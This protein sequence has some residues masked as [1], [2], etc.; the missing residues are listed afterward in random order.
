M[1]FLFKNFFSSKGLI[2]AFFFLFLCFFSLSWSGLNFQ[3]LAREEKKA[4][5]HSLPLA[6]RVEKT[7]SKYRQAVPEKKTLRGKALFEEALKALKE[8]HAEQAEIW[9]SEFL[10][11]KPGSEAA[12]YNLA[13]SLYRQDGKEG[14]AQAYWRQILF[15][16]PYH[17]QSRAG[18]KTL[19][20]RAY[21]WLWLTEDMV[22]ALM[23]LSWAALILALFKKRLYLAR[24]WVFTGLVVHGLGAG[25]FYF[26][27][28]NYST[29][30]RDCSVLS[31]PD[32]AASVLFKQKAGVFLKVKKEL[33]K[34]GDSLQWSHV[35]GFRGKSG[36][37]SSCC[38]LPL[39]PSRNKKASCRKLPQKRT[40]YGE[41]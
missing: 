23:A 28:G 34:K 8:G 20:D 7:S 39:D 37:L 9:F 21:F 27:R 29:V 41:G 38:L 30:V 12:R 11:T 24:S 6:G 33:S 4:K 17:L 10:K 2:K 22:L 15:K 32:S 31:A 14:L 3:A 40:D 13:L 19:G 16:N 36:W 5:A 35:Q 18:L 25:Y 1:R 26:R